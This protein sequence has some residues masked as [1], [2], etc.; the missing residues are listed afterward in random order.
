MLMRKMGAIH[1][2]IPLL[3]MNQNVKFL[4]IV[5]DCLQ[6]L[7][8]GNQETKQ[9]IL[10][11]G[12]T[13]ML[14]G[15]LSNS[16]QY[17]KL[18]LNTT[19]LLKVLSVCNQNK[20]ALVSFNAMQALS[21]HLHH[22]SAAVVNASGGAN[23]VN[24]PSGNGAASTSSSGSTTANDILQNC[25]ITLRNLSDAATRLNGL[26]QLVQNLLQLLSTTTDYTVSTLAAGKCLSFFFL[27]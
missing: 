13:Q 14:V 18:L 24:G 7:A 10:E 20:P 4:S 26:E 17:Q 22:T 27:T 25:L 9:I 23:G 8:F 15:L 19:R 21:M 11:L 16:Q 3:N 2:M 1:Q 6:L 12:G 5:V